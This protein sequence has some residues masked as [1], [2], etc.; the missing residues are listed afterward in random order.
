MGVPG[1]CGPCSGPY[2]DRGPASGRAGGPALAVAR[3]CMAPSHPE[4]A[5][6]YDRIADQAAGEEDAFRATPRQG[7]T[8]WTRP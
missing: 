4:V 2:Y 6:A 1:R 5:A 3:T 8:S 7:T